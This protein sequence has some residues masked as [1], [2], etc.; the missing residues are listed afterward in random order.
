MKRGLVAWRSLVG[1]SIWPASAAVPLTPR[2]GRPRFYAVKRLI[3]MVMLIP[4][5]VVTS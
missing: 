3:Q 2:R 1:E 5:E 4:L